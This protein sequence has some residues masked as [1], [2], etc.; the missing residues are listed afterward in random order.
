MR[1]KNGF[2]PSIADFS[3]KIGSYN[4][5]S[6]R[7]QR[8]PSLMFMILMMSWKHSEERAELMRSLVVAGSQVVDISDTRS[9][10][11]ATHSIMQTLL[12]RVAWPAR[13]LLTNLLD[14]SSFLVLLIYSGCV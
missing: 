4:H 1:S 12:R 6:V 9:S 7:L 13:P 8:A 14:P 3:H 5:R 11:A 2:S 10:I